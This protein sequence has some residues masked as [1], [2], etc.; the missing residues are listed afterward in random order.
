M[1]NKTDK[2]TTETPTYRRFS[3]PPPPKSQTIYIKQEPYVGEDGIYVPLNP[4]V[5]EGLA[6]A[7]KMFL[8]KELFVEAYNKWILGDD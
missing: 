1:K 7:Y 2:I 5:E 3:S 4:Y 6:S 8:S